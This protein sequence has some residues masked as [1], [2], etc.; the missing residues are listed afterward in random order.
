M[1]W[2]FFPLTSHPPLEVGL[3]VLSV[4]FHHFQITLPSSFLNKPALQTVPPSTLSCCSHL[5]FL[6]LNSFTENQRT[7]FCDFFFSIASPAIILGIFKLHM[8]DS[9]IFL[10]PLFLDLLTSIDFFLHHTQPQS[11][12]SYV[13][14]A[15]S[16]TVAASHRLL[17]NLNS[18]K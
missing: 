14:P 13:R 15:L 2:L 12:W 1:W 9:S 11:P 17:F 8:D 16:N 10:V 4:P 5:Q 6:W 3:G 18:M 7:W